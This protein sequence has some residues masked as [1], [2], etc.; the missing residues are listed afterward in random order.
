MTCERNQAQEHKSYTVLGH[1]NG[2]G[3]GTPP[4]QGQAEKDGTVQPGEEKAL[5]R[6]DSDLSVPREQL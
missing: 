2:P 1:K 5:G 6:P 3:D 4:I